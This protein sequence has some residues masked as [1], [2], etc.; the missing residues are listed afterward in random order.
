MRPGHGDRGGGFGLRHIFIINPV[1]GRSDASE[2]LVP[3][4]RQA[5]AAAGV[6]DVIRRTQAP[7]HAARMAEEYARQG[8]PVRLYACGGDGTLNEVMAGV[9]ASGNRQAQVCSVPCGSGNDF[10][11]NFGTQQDFLD[12]EAQIA[13]SP[14]PID[15]M[16][17]DHGVAAAICSMGVDAEVAY[18]IPKFRRIPLCGGQ[19]AY[20]LSIA[21][22][23]CHR[24]G[25]RLRVTLDDRVIEGTYLIATICNGQTYGG[26]YRA[27]PTADLQDGILEV[28]LVKKISRLRIAGVLGRYKEGRHIADNGRVVPEF[29]QILSYHHVRS[30]RLEVL[31]ERT[32]IIN[33]DGECGPART[34]SAR[35]LPA[36]L[37]FVLPEGLYRQFAG[38]KGQEV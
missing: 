37:Q 14:I 10:V 29:Q 16:Q 8:G 12:L 19:T 6:A 32:P 17:T 3:R 30:V 27:A 28:V 13:G 22:C 15:L 21:V 7:G 18:G 36:A 33:V 5:A 9:W 34:L 2:Y 23:M 26:G 38:K 20:N 25:H 24:L 1:S 11:R 4:I 35:V 31:S